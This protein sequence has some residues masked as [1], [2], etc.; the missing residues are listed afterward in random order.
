MY[1]G[2]QKVLFYLSMKTYAKL[3]DWDLHE[4]CDH[5]D[6]DFKC[7]SV[8]AQIVDTYRAAGSSSK[9]SEIAGVGDQLRSKGIAFNIVRSKV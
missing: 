4:M 6:R 9:D 5:E 8:S 2:A 3:I 1:R 7:M